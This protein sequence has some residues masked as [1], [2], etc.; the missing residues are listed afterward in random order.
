MSKISSLGG[1]GQ[2]PLA[3]AQ[4]SVPAVQAAAQSDIG[5][6]GASVAAGQQHPGGATPATEPTP[7]QL[8]ALVA[9][10]QAKVASFNPGLQ[11]SI[12]QNSGKSVVRI[13]D[14]K[15]NEVVWQ[16]PSVAAIQI[17]KALDQFQKGLL[18]NR[19]A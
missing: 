13:T 5:S 2:H 3:T 19:R 16:F 6:A 12:D 10:I 8:N 1:S 17:S 15:T 7:E 18:I 4:S 14:H 9:E 11:F